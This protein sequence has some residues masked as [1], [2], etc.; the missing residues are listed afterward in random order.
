[1]SIVAGPLVWVIL[2]RT[3]IRR[4]VIKHIH[5]I[6]FDVYARLFLVPSDDMFDVRL[7]FAVT[8]ACH[9]RRIA[10]SSVPRIGELHVLID[11]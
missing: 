8:A 1:M 6:V 5:V 2:E 9:Q 10:G 3:D 4:L 7:F 11:V